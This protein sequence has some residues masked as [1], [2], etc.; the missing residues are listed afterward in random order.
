MEFPA[1][2]YDDCVNGLRNPFP[3]HQAELGL[4]RTLWPAAISVSGAALLFAKTKQEAPNCWHAV[5]G[6]SGPGVAAGQVCN[7]AALA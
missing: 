2:Q 1:A 4:Q 6:G 7:I 5:A 3:A